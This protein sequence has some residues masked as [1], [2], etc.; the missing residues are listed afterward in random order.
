MD[1]RVKVHSLDEIMLAMAGHMVAILDAASDG[2]P[3]RGDISSL[4]A[5][6][7]EVHVH[8]CLELE[9]L[10]NNLKALRGSDA[11]QHS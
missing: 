3:E 11:R 2:Q 8:I 7:I 10:N 5:M 9:Q 4:F 6:M 1:G